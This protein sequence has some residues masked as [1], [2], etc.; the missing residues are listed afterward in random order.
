MILEK[1]ILFVTTTMNNKWS[2]YSRK[3]V[4]KFFPKSE[5]LIVDGTYGWWQ[6]WFKWLKEIET[7]QQ[8]YIIHLDDDAFI[9]N[10]DEILK[11]VNLIDENGYS[12]AGIPD[13]HNHIRGTNPV[14]IN[15]FF[16]VANREHLL[17]SWNWDMNKKFNTD[18]IENFKDEYE[19]GF[20][21]DIYIDGDLK[22]KMTHE[23]CD[24]SFS[25]WKGDIYYP[26]F[27]SVLDN[28]HKIKYL[29]PNYGGPIMES[30]NPSIEKGSPEF[31]IHMWFTRE[32]NTPNH[33]NRYLEVE[34]L[35]L[36]NIFKL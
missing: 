17:S 22:H 21:D 33:I 27:W 12:L 7:K 29:Y 32:W 5:H 11:L 25:P 24:L 13:G 16:M 18:W 4:N 30:T 31:L 15:P 2:D 34:S 28:G 6:V 14:C 1:D 8:K 36:E 20:L 23:F 26:L 9:I 10:K 3:L 19:K 35:L